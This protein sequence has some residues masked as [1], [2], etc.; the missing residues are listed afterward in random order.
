MWAYEDV[1]SRITLGFNCN[2]FTNRYDEPEEWTRLCREMGVNAVMFNT[3]LIDPYWPWEVQKRLAD[4]TLEACAKNGIRIVASFGGHHGHQHYLGHPDKGCRREAEQFFRQAIRQTAYLGAKSYGTC[5]AIQTVRTNSDP[6]L[7]GG[8]LE[9][10]LAA[11]R[12]LADYGAEM[13]LRAIA[14]EMTSVPRETCATFA[15]NDYVLEAGAH[16][17]IPLRICLDLGH[18]PRNGTP[19]EAD[20]LA[21]IR[22]YGGRCDVIDCQQT[23]RDASRHWPFTE[24]A[25]RKGVIN[26]TDVVRAIR[27]SGALEVL[28]AF[29]IRTAAFF[30]QED[31]HLED[32]RESVRYWRQ[33]VAN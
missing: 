9:D 21:W 14:Y 29:E 15:E 26:G 24:E 5:F 31:R 25:N 7:R 27:E 18:R 30:P 17:A 11:Y 13:G 12:R 28:L 19:E 23:D 32:L 2:C 8:I 33:W 10:A 16:F 3:D 6:R 20:H 22:R 4:E 1:V